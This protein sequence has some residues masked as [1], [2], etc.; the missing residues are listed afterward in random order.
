MS[1][2]EGSAWY[3]RVRRTTVAEWLTLAR[4]PQDAGCRFM[5]GCGGTATGYARD[6]VTTKIVEACETH[7]HKGPW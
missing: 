5:L 1:I 6:R 4:T 7:R 3:G 2:M